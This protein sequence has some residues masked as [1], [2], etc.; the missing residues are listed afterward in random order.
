MDESRLDDLREA[1]MG[2]V[3]RRMLAKG[4]ITLP[5]VPGLV[6]EY[7]ALCNE[8]FLLLG[9]KFS[10]DELAHLRRVLEEQL[11]TAYSSSPRSDIVVE[12]D[13]PYGLVVNYKVN[14]RWWTV[15]AAYNNWVATRQPPLFGTEPD[16]RVWALASETADPGGCPVLDIG[17]GTGRNS[18]ALARRGHPVDAVEMTEKFAAAIRSEARQQSL[19]IRVIERDVFTADDELLDDYRLILLSEVVS[20]FRDTDQVR[21]VFE[22]ASRRLVPGGHLVFNVFLPLDGYVP[23]SA[24]RELGQQCYTSIFTRSELADAAAGL[25][26]DLV[27]DESVYD[28]EKNGLPPEGWPPTSWYENWV[29]GLDVFE[30]TREDRPIEMRWLVYRRAASDT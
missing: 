30:G 2:R 25:P 6:D 16:A 12:Y 20:D 4:E 7:L 24:A 19:N 23:D 22:L 17:A 5:A 1:M 29:S 18:I 13:S 8:T 21:G 11:Q 9:S 10:D 3:R 15:E 26:L 28:Y 27:S 14:I